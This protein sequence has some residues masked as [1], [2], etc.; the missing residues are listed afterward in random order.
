[1]Q[2]RSGIVTLTSD[3]GSRDAY[4]G[5]MKGVLC[6]I[7]PSVRLVD[8]THEITAQGVQAAAYILGAAYPWFP[9]G[10]VH[11]VVVDPGVGT[12]RRPLVAFADG[13]FFVGPDNG[14][15]TAPLACAD[16]EV[17]T[18]TEIEFALP[19]RSAT[20]H[21]RDVFAPAAGHLA[22]GVALERFGP[23]ANDHV[24]CAMPLVKMVAGDLVGEVLWLDHF[25]NAITNIPRERLCEIGPGPYMAAG[26]RQQYGRLQRTYLDV[27]PGGV[28]ALIGSEGRI[29]IAV[30]QGNAAAQLGLAPGD[31]IVVRSQHEGGGA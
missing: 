31:R 20:F 27:P 21:G 13:Q 1:M 7:M 16:A 19:E 3:F 6:S 4:V 12:P 22:S 28:V 5:A 29:E 30:N 10:T 24:R 14:V 15:L 25:G 26:P 17:H 9:P 18:I 23:R 11:L 8:V 2:T